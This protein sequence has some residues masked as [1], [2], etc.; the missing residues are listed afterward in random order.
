[1]SRSADLDLLYETTN[2]RYFVEFAV[3][4]LTDTASVTTKYTDNFGDGSVIDQ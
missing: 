3:T 2:K 4:Y 1:M